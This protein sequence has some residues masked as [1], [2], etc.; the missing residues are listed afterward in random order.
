M[1]DNIDIREY[2]S[3]KLTPVELKVDQISRAM[4]KTISSAEFEQIRFQVAS[5]SELMQSADQRLDQLE[6][7]DSIGVWLLRQSLVIGTALL[8]GWLTG[9]LRI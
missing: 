9:V 8:I 1:S 2:I 7:H 5:L 6:K 4:D 3:L